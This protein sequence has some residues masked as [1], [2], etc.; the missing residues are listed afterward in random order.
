MRGYLYVL[1]A[2]FFRCTTAL[3]E[4]NYPGGGLTCWSASGIIR[5]ERLVRGREPPAGQR[6]HAAQLWLLPSDALFETDRIGRLR[7][8]RW[9]DCVSGGR[10]KHFSVDRC[11]LRQRGHPPQV[12]FCFRVLVRVKLKLANNI[13][14][15]EFTSLKLIHL[16]LVLIGVVKPEVFS[17]NLER[18]IVNITENLVSEIRH[19]L[20]M[21]SRVAMQIHFAH[22]PLTPNP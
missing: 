2:F 19:Y 18:H 13:G 8:I 4:R 9:L 15:Y 3:V 14:T 12:T 11:G 10:H 20:T 16:Q 7:C 17:N 21:L 1:R 6:G 5:F 22:A